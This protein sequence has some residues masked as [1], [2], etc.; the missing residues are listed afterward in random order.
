MQEKV[1]PLAQGP[2]DFCE[3]VRSSVR[4]DQLFQ[5]DRGARP[6]VP[7][8]KA[9]GAKGLRGRVGL[10]VP[11]FKKNPPQFSRVRLEDLLEDKETL[12][13]VHTIDTEIEGP[14][15]DA[16]LA[17]DVV[18]NPRRDRIVK[19]AGPEKKRIEFIFVLREELEF[20]RDAFG[21]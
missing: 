18:E 19:T 3:P 6:I 14:R 8:K 12:R 1:L 15:R 11:H 4:I 10:D 20:F 16:V 13:G 17:R 5:R 2:D 7:I 21:D 9:L